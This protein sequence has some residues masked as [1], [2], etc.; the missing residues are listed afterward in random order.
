MVGGFPSPT[1]SVEVWVP[2]SQGRSCSLPSTTRGMSHHTVDYSPSVGPVACHARSCEK[3]TA[4]GWTHLAD[5]VELRS[6]HT[7][8]LV[9]DRLL[10]L[11]GRSS[12]RSTEWISLTTGTAEAGP[13]LDPGRTLHCSIQLEEQLIVLTGGSGTLDLVTE[14]RIGQGTRELPRLNTGRWGHG[15]GFYTDSEGTKV[16]VT[17]DFQRLIF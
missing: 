4:T 5:T 10:L 12:S 9:G 17:I 7:S 1:T 8:A 3:L 15:C 13:T 16:T 2:G 14:L 11:G 6:R